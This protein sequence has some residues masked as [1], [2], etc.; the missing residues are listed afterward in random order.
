[1]KTVGL[2]FKGKKAEGKDKAADNKQKKAEGKD[3]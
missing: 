1:M 3:N 2:T